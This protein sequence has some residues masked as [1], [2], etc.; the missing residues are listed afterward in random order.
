[1]LHLKAFTL[2]LFAGTILWLSSSVG[3]AAE[4][5]REEQAAGFVSLFNGKNLDGWQGARDT[6]VVEK[7]LLICKAHGSEDHSTDENLFTSKQYSDFA[8][9]FD[10]KLQPGANN[11]VAIRSPLKGN[12]SKFG[13]EIQILDDDADRYK[14]LA[15]H[16]YHGS[17]YLIAPAKRG[18]LKPTGQWNRQEILFNGRNA[19][20]T[21]NGVVIVDVNLDKSGYEKYLHLNSG[22]TR[23]KGY[24]G[25]LG[26]GSRVE[27]R[28]IRIKEL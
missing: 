6:Y 14:N 17:V 26:H 20:I 12:P 28:N 24:I 19:E 11:G 4:L 1:M 21:L 22:R 9:R 7:G 5:S 2:L 23:T 10:F 18:N 16:Q 15:P 13:M 27:F 8:F 25:F 3:N